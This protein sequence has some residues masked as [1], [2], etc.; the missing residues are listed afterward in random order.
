M[1]EVDCKDSRVR[2]FEVDGTVFKGSYIHVGTDDEG[3]VVVKFRDAFTG[4]QREELFDQEAE[5][6]FHQ[7]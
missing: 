4:I 6:F 2:E 3:F 5:V 1:T 7:E